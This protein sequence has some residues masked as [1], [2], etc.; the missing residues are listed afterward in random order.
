MVAQ[1]VRERH[2]SGHAE[3]VPLCKECDVWAADI[4]LKE[5]ILRIEGFAARKISRPAG[6]LYEK[7]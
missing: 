1:R 5:E 2:E 4:V 6:V 3:R 7:L